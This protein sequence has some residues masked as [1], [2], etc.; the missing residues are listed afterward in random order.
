MNIKLFDASIIAARFLLLALGVVAVGYCSRAGDYDPPE[1]VEL[2]NLSTQTAG[3][4]TES[5]K[6]YGGYPASNMFDGNTGIESATRWL[7]YRRESDAPTAYFVYQFN[8]PT[9]VNAYRIWTSSSYQ[10]REPNT[11]KFFGVNDDETM[12]E[13]DSRELPQ[14]S[15][16]NWGTELARYFEFDN[17][18]AFRSYKFAC[19]KQESDASLMQIQEF[20]MFYVPA[21]RFG[22]CEV[23]HGEDG[24]EVAAQ[25]QVGSVTQIVA[26]ATKNA[27][28]NTAVELEIAKDVVEGVVVT[29]RIGALDADTTYCI[30]V[31]AR[32]EVEAAR[33]NA[34]GI[35]YAGTLVVE[36]LRDTDEGS[37]L[38]AVVRVSRA[39]AD[40]YELP[41]TYSVSSTTAVAGRS[42]VAPSGVA[43]IPAGA[44]YVDLELNPIYDA[45]VTTD[46]IVTYAVNA[47][48]NTLAPGE[49]LCDVTIAECAYDVSKRYVD[50]AVY[51]GGRRA[52]TD[53]DDAYSNI[54]DAVNAANL[55]NVDC[56]IYIK[57]GTYKTTAQLDL[58]GAVRLVGFSGDSSDVIITNKIPYSNQSVSANNRVVKMNDAGAGVY[59]VTLAGAGCSGHGASVYIGAN[60]GTVSNCVMG[61]TA[62]NYYCEVSAVYLGGPNALATHCVVKD[63]RKTNNDVFW[64][65]SQYG[66]GIHVV[67]GTVENCLVKNVWGTSLT[68]ANQNGN[69][70]FSATN[71]VGGVYLA[72]EGA[73]ARNCTVVNCKATKAGGIYAQPGSIVENCVVADCRHYKLYAK[74]KD[75]AVDAWCGSSSAFANCAADGEAAINETCVIGTANTFFEGYSTGDLTPKAGGPIHNAGATPEGWGKNDGRLDLAGR[76]RFVGSRVDIG[77]YELQGTAGMLI[78]IR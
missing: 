5:F 10:G 42:Y 22:D 38:P 26:V 13:L 2:V 62:N 21:M 9:V 35:V 12:E 16:K 76:I 55:A 78:I 6:D 14:S 48:S 45:T 28:P 56:T 73:V 7:A 39:A 70:D 20:Q 33:K 46:Q 50:W 54:V 37:N 18:K 47:Y 59:N 23:L 1:G 65:L 32:D 67:K 51:G 69:Y 19:T 68:G 17:K 43:A 74:E 77:A 29:N 40:P 72:G 31:V 36:K 11:W 34:I 27:D 52:G 41:F 8:T 15:K 49:Q 44:A 53:W 30:D 58:N 25:M 60:G 71:S 66:L 64:N 61:T 24:F 57:P 63:V 4:V 75:E 3:S